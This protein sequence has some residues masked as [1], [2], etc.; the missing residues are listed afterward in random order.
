M[1]TAAKLFAALCFAFTGFFT[2]ELTKP[3]F[4]EGTQFGWYTV[5]V[6][7]LGV[8][9]GWRVMGP[10]AHAARGWTDAAGSGLLTAVVLAFWTFLGFSI[11][12]ML[13][14][15]L[16][17]RFDGI[18]DALTGIVAIAIEYALIVRDAPMAIGWLAVAGTVSG[19]VAHWGARHFR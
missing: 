1:P 9:V 2:A 3:A 6:T 17:M 7:V 18:T 14:R 19:L 15:A 13:Q 4:P 11:W 5:I 16:D 8:L 10:R 12:E